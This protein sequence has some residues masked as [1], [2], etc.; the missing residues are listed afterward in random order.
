MT[1]SINGSDYE[2]KEPGQPIYIIIDRSSAVTSESII[3]IRHRIKNFVKYLKKD[4]EESIRIAI[5]TCGSTAELAAPLSSPGDFRYPPVI[6]D[7]AP[8]IDMRKAL[9]ILITELE[10]EYDSSSPY[11]NYKAC[12]IILS[13]EKPTSALYR[14]AEKLRTLKYITSPLVIT[15][16][17]GAPEFKDL[18]D[19]IITESTFALPLEQIRLF[20]EI[21]G[22]S[23]A[24]RFPADSEL[25][26][27]LAHHRGGE[28]LIISPREYAGPIKITLPV[29]LDGQGATLWAHKGPVVIIQAEG[30]TMKNM[31]IEVTGEPIS[32]DQRHQSA[33]VIRGCSPAFENVEVRGNV[34]GV[35][36]EEG[37]WQ[38]PHSLHLGHLPCGKRHMFKLRIRVPISCSVDSTVSALELTPSQLSP[39]ENDIVITLDSLPQDTLIYGTIALSSKLL[40]RNIYVN[41]YITPP[42]Q[43]SG[44]SESF[45]ESF[46]W[47]P[48]QS[49]CETRRLIH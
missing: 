26:H 13:S 44:Y 15:T 24:P 12:I 45:G 29:I 8:G 38:Y 7:S 25:I 39:G 11:H 40:K 36:E 6:T 30:V 47:E 21:G 5:I 48:E 19:R 22:E 32:T 20:E 27:A 42:G 23:A 1:E 37:M 3:S 33:L 4:G 46:I 9:K 16:R 35:A 28:P 34:I 2:L 43:P 14:E 10:R 49:S 41:A 31:K 17:S 18:T